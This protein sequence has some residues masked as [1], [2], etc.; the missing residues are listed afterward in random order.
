MPKRKQPT[1]DSQ[2]PSAYTFRLANGEAFDVQGVKVL[3][4]QLVYK[5]IEFTNKKL[6][7]APA[8]VVEEVHEEAGSSAREKVKV[9]RRRYTREEKKHMINLYDKYPVKEAAMEVCL[10][11][12]HL[13]VLF[14]LT[15][16]AE[17]FISNTLRHSCDILC[18]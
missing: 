3:V 6:L 18:R 7:E 4:E 16:Y 8:P 14:C 1:E 13:L 9:G 2:N 12:S 5:S 11:K 17:L 15:Y 10:T